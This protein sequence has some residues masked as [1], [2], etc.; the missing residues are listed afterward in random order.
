MEK[1]RD[2]IAA[3]LYGG[4]LGDALGYAVEFIDW[5]AIQEQYGSDGIREPVLRNGKARVSDDTQM[6]LF[7][8]EGYGFGYFRASSRGIGADV[9]HYIYQSYLCWLQTQGFPARSVWD[10]ISRLK[11]TP[12]MNSCRSP[13]RT[14]IHALCSNQM[15]TPDKP[16]NDSKGCGGV[17]RTAPLGFIRSPRTHQNP[18]GVPLLLG[19]RVAAITHGHPLG[20]MPAGMLSDIIDRCIYGNYASLRNLIDDALAETVQTFSRYAESRDLEALIRRAAALAERPVETGSTAVRTDLSAIRS[21]GAGWVGEEALAI[22]VY[23][24]LRYPND[25]RRALCAAVNHDGDSDSTGAIAGNILGAYLG[26]DAIPQDW[27]EKLELREEIEEIADM[28][29]R[30]L[31]CD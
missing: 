14:C 5:T 9:E 22:A 20:W 1:T 18:F 17:M 27:L 25:L 11:K 6:T 7:T 24:V 28:M 21:L 3:S 30:I 29:Q 12:D 10:P 16:I 2:R 31:A 8:A 19:A 15:G 13:G 26:M 23:A 4:A